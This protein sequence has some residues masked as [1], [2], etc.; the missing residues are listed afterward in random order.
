[1]KTKERVL[2]ILYNSK[3]SEVS[4]EEIAKS[5]CVSRNSVW[6]SVNSLKKDGYLIYTS[7]NG[8]MLDMQKELFTES[9]IKKYLKDDRKILLFDIIDSTNNMAK[10]LAQNGEGEGTVVIAKSQTNGKGRMGRSFISSSENGLYLTIIL[11]PR[12]SVDKCVNI[13]V[14]GAVSLCEAI[15]ELCGVEC[16]IK[17]VNDIYINEKKVSGILTEASINFE[18][19][20]MQYAVIGMGINVYEPVGGFD[21][22]IKDIATAIYEKEIQGDVKS[23]LC[24]MIIDRFFY[25]YSRIEEK[26]YLQKY[27]EKSMIIDKMV[28]VYV[29]D[30]IISGKAIDIDENANLVVE[31]EQGVRKFNSGEARVRKNKES[32][33]N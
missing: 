9:N 27:K 8:Y 13:T 12:V 18:G 31:T 5:L 15:E 10:Q 7:P 22:E 25:H 3:G 24:A 21:P 17:W 32:T 23:K 33:S 11:R 2:Q 1:M 29:G 30:Q 6:K 20:T 28:D 16:Q 4:G 26:S 19:G 14:L